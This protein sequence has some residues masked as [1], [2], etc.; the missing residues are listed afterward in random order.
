MLTKSKLSANLLKLIAIAAMLVDH[1]AW[2]YVDTH[3]LLGQTLHFIGRI[4]IVIMSFFIA[5]GYV[6]TRNVKKYA[7]RLLIFALISEIPYNI[8]KTQTIHY[9]GFNV[10]FTLLLAL[11]AVWIYDTKEIKSRIIKILAI[12][13]IIIL[14]D[15]CDWS[16]VPILLTLGF[17]ISRGKASSSIG[18]TAL[19]VIAY[20]AKQF[21]EKAYLNALITYNLPVKLVLKSFFSSR[22]MFVG[23]FMGLA[24]VLLY[25]GRLGKGGKAMKWL[26]YI[27]YP[28]HMLILGAIKFFIK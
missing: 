19:T 17:F 25:N 1:V 11:L 18:F 24:L 15:N 9:K 3:S 7:L 14:S 6:H 4:T 27:F 5:E 16:F 12:A 28:A 20:L 23:L 10:I 8:F 13:A 22:I 2:Q 26:F 21:V